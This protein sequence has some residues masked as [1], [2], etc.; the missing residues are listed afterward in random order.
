MPKTRNASVYNPGA[1]PLR[2]DFYY[3][4][5]LSKV[6]QLH[7][8]GYFIVFSVAFLEAVVLVGGIVPGATIV[9]FAGA[10]ASKGQF[11]PG[12]LMAVAAAGAIF[13]DAASY[14]LGLHATG[15][16]KAY[17]HYL[18]PEYLETTHKFFEKH[19]ASSIFFGRFVGVVR[20]LVPFVAGLSKMEVRKFFLWNILS[21]VAWS[22]SHVLLGFS[23]GKAWRRFEVWS[24]RM[25]ILVVIL[26]VI[27]VAAWFL[28][29]WLIKPAK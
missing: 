17:N 28:R 11:H 25:A 23:L 21:G 13:G 15:R 12:L 14:W 9:V 29:R 6:G 7:T 4:L 27:G 1:P 22:V 16:F 10:L 26:A 24:G 20:M 8:A 2:M 3:E 5:L 19:G 18:K